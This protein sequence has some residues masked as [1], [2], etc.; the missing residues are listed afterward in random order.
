MNETINKLKSIVYV[1]LSFTGGLEDLTITVRRPNGT[2]FDTI[3]MDEQSGGI[4]TASYTPDA[5]GIWQEKVSSVTNGD[6]VIRAYDVVSYD[7][8][9]VKT[10]VDTVDGKVDTI[11]SNV[12]SVKTTVETTDGKVDVVDSNVDSV[13][14]TVETTDGKVDV[15]DSNVDS[16]KATVETTDGKVDTV[17][18]KVDIVDTNVDSVKAKTDNLPSDT[19]GE[20]GDIKT[21]V[22]SIASENTQGGYFA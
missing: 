20:L 12:D 7:V 1:P 9:D 13:K 14:T 5:L 19:A 8:N 6:L 18:G 4:Y 17:D 2:I 3:V 22:D 11:D 15:V 21:V 10:T 16:V